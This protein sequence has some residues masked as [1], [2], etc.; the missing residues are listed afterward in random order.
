[1]VI[2]FVLI[3]KKKPA[4]RAGFI[5]SGFINNQKTTGILFQISFHE[6]DS[7]K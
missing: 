1:M 2:H 5:V 6:L 3:A 4:Q 7:F